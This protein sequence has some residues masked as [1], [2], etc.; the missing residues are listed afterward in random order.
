MY[1]YHNYQTKMHTMG[2]Q[3]CKAK[4]RYVLWDRPP[5]PKIHQIHN[6]GRN[7]SRY[8]ALKLLA[9]EGAQYIRLKPKLMRLERLV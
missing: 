6:Y 9:M 4:L 2:I 3:A 5:H 7:K 8:V 1:I